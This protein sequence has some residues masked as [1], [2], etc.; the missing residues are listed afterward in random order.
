MAGE[1]ALNCQINGQVAE[2]YILFHMDMSV[3]GLEQFSNCS[4]TSNLWV[5]KLFCIAFLCFYVSKLSACASNLLIL[6]SP[7][8]KNR[9]MRVNYHAG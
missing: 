3:K 4:I 6:F 1:N 7:F 9:L 5:L 2:N 8:G